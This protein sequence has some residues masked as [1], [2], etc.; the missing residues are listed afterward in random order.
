MIIECIIFQFLLLQ[1][2]EYH[3]VKPHMIC[4]SFSEYFYCIFWEFSRLFFHIL[5][6]TLWK[7]LRYLL[8]FCQSM[9]HIHSVFFTVPLVSLAFY[10]F[11]LLI[12]TVLLFFPSIFKFELFV[13]SLRLSSVLISRGR[14]II[15]TE[16]LVWKKDN[17]L[18][19]LKFA[20]TPLEW[21]IMEKSKQKKFPKEINYHLK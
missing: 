14:S 1:I 19:W 4:T 16:L 17:I 20:P 6:P 21:F 5:L 10:F 18:N 3:L 9:C 15:M 11:L 13:S 8:S 2:I 7:H 12:F